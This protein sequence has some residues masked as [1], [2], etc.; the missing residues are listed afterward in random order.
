MVFQISI[1]VVGKSFTYGKIL[2]DLSD[3]HFTVCSSAGLLKS[4][5][6][7]ANYEFVICSEWL[8]LP[9]LLQLNSAELQSS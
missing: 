1:T 2:E 4:F 3:I 9:A 7:Y 5:T 6:Y 8:M